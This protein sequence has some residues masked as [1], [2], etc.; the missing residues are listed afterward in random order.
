MVA[1]LAVMVKVGIV[2]VVV[3]SAAVLEGSMLPTRSRAML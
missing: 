1:L 3:A 2:I